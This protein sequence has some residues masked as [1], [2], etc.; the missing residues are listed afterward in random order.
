MQTYIK[1]TIAQFFLPI[2]FALCKK[3]AIIWSAIP[4]LSAVLLPIFLTHA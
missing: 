3:T 1:K 4:T 2:F